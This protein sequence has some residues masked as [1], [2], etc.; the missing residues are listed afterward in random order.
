MA[1]ENELNLETKKNA[2]SIIQD[3]G[4]EESGFWFLE[5][6]KLSS[7]LSKSQ[8][9]T[10]ILYAFVVDDEVAYIG[11]SVQSLFKRMYLYKNCG[12]SQHTN[13][14]N[15]ASI[16]DCLEQGK[17]VRIY[18]FIQQVPMEYKGIPINLA[19]GLEDNLIALLKP[20]WNVTGNY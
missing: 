15:H 9:E 11:K 1:I 8:K 16:K 13:I 12:P 14:R 4:F 7:N 10:N 20:Y 5:N 18:A 3:L 6:S 17:T 2:V 19:A